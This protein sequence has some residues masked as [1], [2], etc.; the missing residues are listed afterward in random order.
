MRKREK[1]RLKTLTEEEPV[2]SKTVNVAYFEQK[3]LLIDLRLL[4]DAFDHY[5]AFSANRLDEAKK[6][7]RILAATGKDLM[8]EENQGD[9]TVDLYAAFA[10]ETEAVA[11]RSS[12]LENSQPLGLLMGFLEV[13]D[14]VFVL[15][16]FLNCILVL[17]QVYVRVAL[18]CLQQKIAQLRDGD[19]EY[20][21][22][23][24]LKR[25]D[26]LQ[27]SRKISIEILHNDLAETAPRLSSSGKKWRLCGLLHRF[28][29]HTM[30]SEVRAD[31]RRISRLSKNKIL[32]RISRTSEILM[33]R[34]A[35]LYLKLWNSPGTIFIF[36]ISKRSALFD[37]LESFLTTKSLEGL[38]ASQLACRVV[39]FFRIVVAVQ[40]SNPCIIHRAR[41]FG[42]LIRY[43]QRQQLPVLGK[44]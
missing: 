44:L 31:H 42:V 43:K 6:I 15:Q 40:E 19:A 36:L 9:V 16:F 5:N 37:L 2:V 10:L 25:L 41:S 13:D 8:D 35:T 30:Q 39:L 26:D 1:N 22:L 20:S 11:E 29:P 27:L 33:T 14:C 28:N 18:C 23:V 4:E 38:H 34:W 17:N 3:H 24:N 21:L 7:G 12:E 32:Q